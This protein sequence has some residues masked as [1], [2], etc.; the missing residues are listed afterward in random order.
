MLLLVS[1]IG[2]TYGCANYNIGDVSRG[3]CTSV[4]P[5]TRQALHQ[6]VAASYPGMSLV[7][8]CKMVGVPLVVL[9]DV[10]SEV[11]DAP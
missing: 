8:Y 9:G 3:Y 11:V 6:M 7:D 5:V 2:M 4:D 1:A 10:V